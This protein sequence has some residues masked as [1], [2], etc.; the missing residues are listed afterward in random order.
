M[1][2]QPPG[3][4]AAHAA[5]LE[6]I[7]Q[8]INNHKDDAIERCERLI[9]S[10][11]AA[12]D[13]AT[14]LAATELYGLVKN[15]EGRNLLFE[16]LQ[17][18]EATQAFAAE[19]RL[20]E[21]IARSYYT[22][23]EYRLATQYW[24][25]CVELSEQPGGEAKS[26][27]YGKVGLGQV[28]DALGNHAQAVAHH[29]A[30]LSRMGE[31]HDHYLA[32]KIRIN[33]A[34]NLVQL[35]DRIEARV[36]LSEALVVCLEHY[37]LD[38]A[39]E[40]RFRLGEISLAEGDLAQASS[41]LIEARQLAQTVAYRWV[42]VNAIAL[43]AEVNIRLGNPQRALAIANEGIALAEESDYQ[44]LLQR[45]HGAAARYAEAGGDVVLAYS[46]L[47]QHVR[48][49]GQMGRAAQ[50]AVQGDA[51]RPSASRRLAA[52]AANPQLDAPDLD[53]ARRLVLEEA[54]PILGISAASA[55]VLDEE[56]GLLRCVAATGPAAPE[57]LPAWSRQA[58]PAWFDWLQQAAPLVAHDALHHRH[59]WEVTG[60]E[61]KQRGIASLMAW[62]LRVGGRIRG[63]L[64]VEHR[65]NQR[66]WTPDDALLGGMLADLMVR[67]LVQ[68]ERRSLALAFTELTAALDQA[69][70]LLADASPDLPS[71]ALQLARV[72]ELI[73][74]RQ[75]LV[76][77]ADHLAA[78]LAGAQ[79]DAALLAGRLQRWPGD[80]GVAES[81]AD[82]QR[83][84]V[85]LEQIAHALA[86]F[87]DLAPQPAALVR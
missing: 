36:L 17:L 43:Q 81:Q 9:R 14:Q 45:L 83:L 60:A 87:R 57:V 24:T 22:T 63:V 37:L 11:R 31:E 7:R 70:A 55:W 75:H 74:I 8:R 65:G 68:H 15:Y 50:P 29:R 26:W 80:E 39:A 61:L 30:A 58:Y 71:I 44:H 35:G 34:V 16:A 19:A 49:Q 86:E 33:L 27:I 52:L 77:L 79:A 56:A 85:R 18:A 12:H 5:E 84:L 10:A 38:Y 4:L 64:L 73:Q 69:N 1:T 66:N 76:G 2:S 72:H 59:A 46:H 62:S 48:Y 41:D 53:A 54:I 42:E 23:G 6:A 20:A 51:L 25:R 47:Q 67:V 78:P 40:A 32:A 82:S 28:Y 21:Q 13:T 3:I